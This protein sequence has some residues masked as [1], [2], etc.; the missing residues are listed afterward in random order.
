MDEAVAVVP[1]E[2]LMLALAPKVVLDPT[3]KEELPPTVT[4]RFTVEPLMDSSSSP[5]TSAGNSTVCAQEAEGRKSEQKAKK[6]KIR[7]FVFID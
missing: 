4:L 6:T 7:Y 1:G 2:A 5:D 3:V